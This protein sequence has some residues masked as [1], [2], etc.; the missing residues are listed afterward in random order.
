MEAQETRTIAAKYRR[1]SKPLRIATVLLPLLAMVFAVLYLTHMVP[2]L[3]FAY[4]YLMVTLLLPLIFIWVPVKSTANKEGLP[5]YDALLAF[6]GF[7]IPLYFFIRADAA[8]M[9][10]GTEP[11]TIPLV[12]AIVLWAMILEASRRAVGWVFFGVVLFFSVYPLFGSIMPGPLWAPAFQVK[13]L[14]AF[15]VLGMDSLMGIVM[16]VFGKILF[17]FFVFAVAIQAAGAGRLFN[18]LAMALL[19]NT[20][21]GPAK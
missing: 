21:G 17:G 13:E 18:N 4:L 19:G 14:T 12:L 3:E 11:P 6:L 7:A 20:R 8:V 5:W 9:S 16:Q 1:P 10:W 15:Y 2:W